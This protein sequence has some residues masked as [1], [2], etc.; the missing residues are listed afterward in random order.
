MHYA[1]A[2]SISL[3]GVFF[4]VA[5]YITNGSNAIDI[6]PALVAIGGEFP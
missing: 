3:E 4:L 2:V 1:L 6:H 5:A